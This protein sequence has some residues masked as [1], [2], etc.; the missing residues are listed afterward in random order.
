MN[1]F[2]ILI[3]R[4]ETDPSDSGS[5]TMTELVNHLGYPTFFGYNSVNFQDLVGQLLCGT[6]IFLLLSLLL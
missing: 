4:S 2:R 6:F 1:L 5:A 3:R